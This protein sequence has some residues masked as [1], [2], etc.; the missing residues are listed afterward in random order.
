MTKKELAHIAK[1]MKDLQEYCRFSDECQS[2]HMIDY[3][4]VVQSM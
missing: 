2:C 4:A 3:W 1:V